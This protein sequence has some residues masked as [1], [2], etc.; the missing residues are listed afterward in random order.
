MI[1]YI[2]DNGM[3]YG[4]HS[5]YFVSVPDEYRELD[6]DLRL[7]LPHLIPGGPEHPHHPNEGKHLVMVA[8]DAEAVQSGDDFLWISLEAAIFR[9]WPRD[10]CIT[11]Q[12]SNLVEVEP[13]YP[14]GKKTYKYVKPYERTVP[15]GDDIQAAADRLMDALP[16]E[17]FT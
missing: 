2:I 8:R 13:R 5:L 9:S 12:V 6:P 10:G 4:D 11:K 3:D 16:P 1:Y 15:V 7:V 17:W 14:H